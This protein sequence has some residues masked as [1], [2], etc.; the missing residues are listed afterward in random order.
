LTRIKVD[1]V[2]AEDLLRNPRRASKAKCRS[3]KRISALHF[4]SDTEVTTA[5]TFPILIAAM[6]DAHRRPK[7]EVLDALLGDEKGQYVI[8]SAV[9][10]GRYMASK[11]FTSFP[12]N[13]AEGKMPSVV[14]SIS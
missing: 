9:D 1:K 13:L 12:A 3:S 11:M 14:I 10:P 4:V 8:R 6:E 5:L 7:M 2:L